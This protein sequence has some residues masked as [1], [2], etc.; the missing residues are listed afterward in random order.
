[1]DNDL[2]ERIYG[3]FVLIIFLNLLIPHVAADGIIIPEPMPDIPRTTPLAIKYHHVNISIDN[4]Y[5]ETKVDQVFL[6]EYSRDLEG[7]YIFP[8]PKEA[9]ISGF[10]M[11]VDGEELTGEL[12]KK[13]KAR[14]IYEDIVRRMKDPALLEY[15]ERDMF[16]V[17]IYPIPARG[18]KR[19]TLGYSE[20][21]DC[22]SGICRYVYPLEPEKY[23]PTPLE[24]VVINVEIESKQSIKAIYSPSHKI[25]VKRVDDFNV[26]V[27]YEAENVKPDKDFILYYTVSDEDFGVNLLTY[28][29]GSEDGFFMLMLAPKQEVSGEDVIPKDFIFVL[30]TSGSMSGEKIRQ[31]KNA[32]K[33]CINNLNERDRFNII[34]FSTDV[35]KF[36]EEL[37]AANSGDIEEA[38]KFIDGI[39]AVGGTNIH[40][41]LLDALKYSNSN[42]ASMTVFLTDGKPTVGTT[43]IEKILVDTK[44]ANKKNSRIFVFGVGYDVNTHLLDKLS[45][46][47]K[48]VSEY[49]KPEEDIEVKVSSFYSKVSNPILSDLSLEFKGITVEEMYPKEISD[50]F[51]GSQLIRFGRYSGSGDTLVELTGWVGDKERKFIYEVG[52]PKE[53][54]D[55]EFI[56]RLWATRKIGYLLD[57]IR[58]HGEDKELVDEVIE[59]SL[60]Y[61]IM[62]PYTSFLVEVDTDMGRP[63][64]M[65]ETKNM[66]DS[67][68]AKQGFRAPTGG[69]AVDSAEA[70]R[71][72]RESYVAETGSEKVKHLGAKT[73][74]SKKGV[75]R[76]NDYSGEKAV[77]VK[78][79]SDTYFKLL[80]DYPEVGRYLSLGKRVN[81][82]YR[83]N[84]F[85]VGEEGEGLT[86]ITIPSTTSTISST[87]ST[88]QKDKPDA[89]LGTVLI[90]AI[91]LAISL[92]VLVW[93]RKR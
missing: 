80:Q 58:L 18:E 51:K 67:I 78:Y 23:S 53:N 7:T 52:F 31:A 72:L 35:K 49:V 88:I 16:K 28:R 74:Y 13:D 81:F 64:H 92:G 24:S 19:V 27:S 68:L 60:E 21:I 32:L 62:T 54:Q 11:Y 44:D 1:M 10:S 48:G 34:T 39:D 40:D 65:E 15:V 86:V 8:L 17:R 22:D 56:P 12:L 25:S 59:L 84:C 93:S 26:E 57:E 5:A 76:D 89:L 20:V 69:S 75:W 47:N 3:I 91:V 30:D 37:A 45:G 43:D 38:L 71:D 4:Q 79:G 66:F 33:F 2:L 63:V 14:R 55:N 90:I 42:R 41:A 6:N 29:E 9:S 77:H 82:C 85:S 61:G 87:S 73:F 46:Q 50:L 83:N 36:R 70:T